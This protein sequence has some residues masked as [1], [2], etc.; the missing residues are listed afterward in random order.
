LR[1]PQKRV[2]QQAGQTND[3]LTTQYN[4][5]NTAVQ[6]QAGD[7]GNIMNAYKNLL[8]GGASSDVR[9]ATKNLGDLA[10]TGGLSD[11]DI[12]NIRA[13]G[14]SPIR[15]AYSAAMRNV[16]RQRGLQGGYSPN[17]AAVQAKLAREQS[18]QLAQGSTNVEAEI[19]KLRQQ[20]RLAAAPEY[21]SAASRQSEIPL[22]AAEGMTSLY[23]T[24]PALAQ[25]FGNQA[26]QGAQ[27][28]NQINQQGQEGKLQLI[29]QLM[30]RL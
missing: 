6:Q 15:A 2:Q 19:A 23:G 22:R 17:Y 9:A 7:Y 28:Q 30:G 16:D 24:T 21:S 26:L 13:R 29:G 8:S 18:E 1:L 4:L 14:V 5:Y 20:G 10:T 12:A 27:F 11:A 25:L 3:P